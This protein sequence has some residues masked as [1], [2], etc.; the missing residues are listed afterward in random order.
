MDYINTVKEILGDLSTPSLI[1]R[2]CKISDDLLNLFD[3]LKSRIE[4]IDECYKPVVEVVKTRKYFTY[5]GE[6]R[7]NELLPFLN[8][9]SRIE[10]GYTELSEDEKAKAKQI[11]LNLK[12]F[13]TPTC[14][15]CPIVADYLYQLAQESEG[16]QLEVY[17]IIEYDELQEKYRVYNVPKLVINDKLSLPGGLPK[18]IILKTLIVNSLRR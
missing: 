12:L 6:P 17:D 13:V 18:E 16:L 5:Y 1:L 8:S 7:E 9:L 4:V 15:V 2:V 14:T 11:S 3:Y 10:K